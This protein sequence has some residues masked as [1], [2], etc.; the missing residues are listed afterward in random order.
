MSLAIAFLVVLMF[1]LP[2]C[3]GRSVGGTG[4]GSTGNHGLGE[5]PQFNKAGSGIN[6]GKR[7]QG[8]SSNFNTGIRKGGDK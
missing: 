7:T 2:G 1:F 5:S 3:G 4:S 8:G 6:T